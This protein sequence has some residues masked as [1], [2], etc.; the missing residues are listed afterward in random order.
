MKQS[1]KSVECE[2]MTQNIISVSVFDPSSSLFKQKANTRAEC[3]IVSCSLESCPL[4]DKGTCTYMPILGW[5]KCPYG[6]FRR[7]TGPTK[8]AKEFR[9]WVAQ[10]K[11]NYKDI[12]KLKDPSRKIA[13]IGGYVYLPYAHMAMNKD[14]P[15]LEHSNAFIH[16]NSFLPKESWT[17]ETVIKILSFRP[18]ALMG[19]A[20][21]QYENEQIPLFLRHLREEDPK[22]WGELIKR[23]PE[24]NTEVD[25]VGRKAY[26][27]T[28]NY[29]I[30]WDSRP[31]DKYN[32][33]WVWDGQYVK[34]EGQHAYF[35]TWGGI[36]L[37]SLEIRGIPSKNAV[38]VISDNSWVNEKTIFQD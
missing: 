15:F 11:E 36:G 10:R 6:T 14:I 38:I 22:M 1:K 21:T 32:V 26:L 37:E 5:H 7:E 28:L 17:I 2:A 30:E 19:G 34:T 33:H 20:I 12:P 4:R 8:R 35:S 27:S 31:N 29:P 24:L 23:H 3:E 13:F 9:K 18:T 25:Y 16:G